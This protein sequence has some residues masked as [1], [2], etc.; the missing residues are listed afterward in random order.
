MRVCLGFYL[1]NSP[2][3]WGRYLGGGTSGQAIDNGILTILAAIGFGV[4]AQIG[5]SVARMTASRD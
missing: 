2:E 4:L 1:A 5:S 3:L